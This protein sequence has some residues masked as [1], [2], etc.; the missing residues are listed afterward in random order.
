MRGGIFG[1]AAF[2]DDAEVCGD[3]V[4][5]AVICVYE[6]KEKDKGGWDVREVNGVV[7]KS[8]DDGVEVVSDLDVHVAYVPVRSACGAPALED[9][10]EFFGGEEEGLYGGWD[11]EWA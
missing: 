7:R 4:E 9:L 11:V 8:G 2:E 1:E 10:V 3:G 6:E 5:V